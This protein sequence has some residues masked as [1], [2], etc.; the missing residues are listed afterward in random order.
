MKP[1][2]RSNK[3]GRAQRNTK[4]GHVHTL[5]FIFELFQIYSK[6][7]VKPKLIHVFSWKFYL[8]YSSQ[9]FELFTKMLLFLFFS[10]LSILFYHHHLHQVFTILSL[11]LIHQPTMNNQ[12]E[13]LNAPKFRFLLFISYY[14]C[15]QTTS[16]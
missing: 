14:L 3:G 8:P 13:T 7:K 12:F 10:E 6:Q 15:T 9:K 2:S 11:S 16:L 4:V 5:T 1:I